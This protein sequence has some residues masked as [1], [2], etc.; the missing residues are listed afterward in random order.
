MFGLGNF[1][2]KWPSWFLKILKL[3]LL[4]SSN[5][6]IFKN[7]LGKFIPNRPPKHV[8]TSTNFILNYKVLFN[9]LCKEENIPFIISHSAIDVKK[10]FNDIKLHLNIRGSRKLKEN[11]VKYLKGFS[12]LISATQNESE[13]FDGLSTKSK[14]SFWKFFKWWKLFQRSITQC[15]K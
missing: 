15:F 2:N 6:K 12:S 3:H 8:I 10:N 5:F 7:A 11:F 13:S 1:R 4:Y 14:E 9:L